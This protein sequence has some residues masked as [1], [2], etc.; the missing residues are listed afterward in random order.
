[1][2][3]GANTFNKDHPT[4]PVIITFFSFLITLVVMLGL[5][6]SLSASQ[7]HRFLASLAPLPE[8]GAV[9]EETP[10]TE[11]EAVETTASLEVDEE[12]D[13]DSEAY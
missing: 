2:T 8:G 12:N 11:S 4:P 13:A 3:C 5:S 10:V 7:D 1:M 9:P 6:E